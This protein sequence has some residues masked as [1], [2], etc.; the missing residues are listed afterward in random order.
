M[1][2]IKSNLATTFNEVVQTDLFFLWDQTFQLM[3]DEAVRWKSG[4]HLP[5]KLGSTL[6]RNIV[7]MWIRLWGPPTYIMSDQEGGLVSTEA[8]RFCDRFNITRVLVGKGGTSTKGLIER[9]VALTKYVMLRS[10][11]ACAREGLDL[12]YS[13]I[14][15]EC[16]MSQN[17]MLEYN[18]GTPQQALVGH[19]QRPWYNVDSTTLDQIAGAVTKRPDYVEQAIRGRLLAKQCIQEGLIQE[20]VA[21]AGTMR[22]YKHDQQLLV[23]GQQVDI[24]RQPNRKDEYGWHGPAEIISLERR[25]GSAIVKHQGQP[26]IIPLSHLRKHILQHLAVWFH[27]HDDLDNACHHYQNNHDDFCNY[28]VCHEFASQC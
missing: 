27:T 18:G 10:K 17:L 21:R 15:Q 8:T 20:R 1:A 6:V 7:N 28:D 11:A 5:N 26:L 22:Q 23:P 2:K 3:V 12:S 24:W 16:C 4:D 9:H 13:E 14:C 25:A 19:Y